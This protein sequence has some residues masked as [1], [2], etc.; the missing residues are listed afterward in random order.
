MILSLSELQK[1]LGAKVGRTRTTPWFRV[2]L[3]LLSHLR[4]PPPG[5][6]FNDKESISADS[7]QLNAFAWPVLLSD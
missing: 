1:A 2:Y 4:Y 3:V 5:R 6:A 7:I